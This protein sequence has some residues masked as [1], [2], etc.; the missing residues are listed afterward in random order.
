MFELEQVSRKNILIYDEYKKAY[1][2]DLQQYQSRIYPSE[3]SEILR[4]YHIRI[5]EEYV[6][7]IW[8]EKNSCDDF[9]ILGIFITNEIYR[10]NGIGKTAIKQII[11]NDLQHMQTNKVLLR[12]R[13]KNNRA[14]RCYKSVGFIEK[15][16]YEKENLDIIEMI[17]EDKTNNE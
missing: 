8:L 1:T 15:Q 4:W 14:I 16:R 12:V 9:A 7:A 5:K 17:Y 6:G 11:K 2:E 13:E 10:N 3:N